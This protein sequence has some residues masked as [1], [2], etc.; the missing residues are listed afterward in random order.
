MNAIDYQQVTFRIANGSH[1]DFKIPLPI[2]SIFKA[3]TVEVERS[4]ASGYIQAQAYLR[5]DDQAS[6]IRVLQK[7]DEG[8]I[9]NNYLNTVNG[10]NNNIMSTIGKICD[11]PIQKS[12][13]VLSVLVSNH[14]GNSFNINVHTI[15]ENLEQSKEFTKLAKE[16]EQPKADNKPIWRRLF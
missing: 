8:A 5:N 14:T 9:G 11:I 6:N 13:L 7:L 2:N 12:G 10:K 3:F 4:N 15:V 1:N 16:K